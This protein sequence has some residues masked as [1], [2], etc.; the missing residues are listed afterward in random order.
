MNDFGL[1]GILIQA[2]GNPVVE[3]HAHR[4]EHIALVGKDV[5]SII[6]VH[7]QHTNCLRMIG[8]N[9]THTKDGPGRRN[10]GLFN[11]RF[12]FRFGSSQYYALSKN[13]KRSF[14]SIDQPCSCFDIFFANNGLGAIAADMF[15]FFVPF[16]SEQLQLC[17]FGNVNQNRS[18]PSAF[19][20]VKCLGND[21]RNFRSIGH[22]KIPFGNRRGNVYYIN[23][24]ECIGTQQVCKHLPRNTYDWRGVQHGISQTRYQICCAGAA[25]SKHYAHI[26]GCSSI[27]L[28]SMNGA[29]FVTDQNMF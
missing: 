23:F 14:G 7:A 19:G 12:K 9:S 24:L 27:A 25:G 4:N 21:G 6:S 13:Y 22:L 10:A 16:I 20:Y 3:T 15:A 8:R 17:I 29:L 1:L 18:G 11:K 5:G 26:A 28:C 2:A